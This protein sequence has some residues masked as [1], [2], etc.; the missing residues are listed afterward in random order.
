MSEHATRHIARGVCGARVVPIRRMG[1]LAAEFC[2]QV[3]RVGAVAA[4]FERSFYLRSADAFLCVGEPSIGDGPL[5]LVA[6]FADGGLAA[7]D[8]RPGKRAALSAG[9]ITIG[10]T[11]RLD[12]TDCETW[13]PPDWPAAAPS[14]ETAKALATRAAAEAPAEGFARVVFGAHEPLHDPPFARIARQR[15]AHFASWVS[16]SLEADGAPAGDGAEGIGGLVG[17]GPGLT[18]SGDDFLCGA[19]ALLDALGETAI[20][21]ALGRAIAA[22]APERTAPLSACFLRAAAERHI[23]SQLHRATASLVSGDIDASI[24]AIRDVG[25]SSGWDMLT[26]IAVTLDAVASWRAQS[27]IRAAGRPSVVDLKFLLLLP[28]PREGTSNPK[29]H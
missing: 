6:N 9:A 8:V 2:R 11:V 10:D 17:L 4:V 15:I 18:P 24:A 25:H 1:I 19:F 16:D 26:G 23:G 29:P 12:L 14:V 22:L 21:G 3:G 7:L 13:Q 5:T 20:H 28:R 27:G